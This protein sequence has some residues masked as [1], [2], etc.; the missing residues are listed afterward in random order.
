MGVFFFKFT[1]LTPLVSVNWK[2]RGF[3]GGYLFCCRCCAVLY[4]IL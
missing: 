2:G 3:R 1:N 4:D